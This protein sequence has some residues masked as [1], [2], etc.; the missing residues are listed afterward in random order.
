[1][2]ALRGPPRER[3]FRFETT[4]KGPLLAYFSLG[5]NGRSWP[6]SDR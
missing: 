1:M 2:S 5:T 6:I 4:P 3:L